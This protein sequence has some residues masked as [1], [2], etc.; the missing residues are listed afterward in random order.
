MKDD[1]FDFMKSDRPEKFRPEIKELKK[2][3]QLTSTGSLH[4]IV[5]LVFAPIFHQT[6]S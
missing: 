5:R 1:S 4:C 2:D 3:E 6:G